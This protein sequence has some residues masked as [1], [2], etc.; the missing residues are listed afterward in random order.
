MVKVAPIPYL[1]RGTNI[2][3]NEGFLSPVE[4]VY[5]ERWL[6]L[7][8]GRCSLQRLFSSYPD[9]KLGTGLL[10]LRVLIGLITVF[11]AIRWIAGA[12]ERAAY[13]WV[14]GI[15]STACGVML[16]LGFKTLLAGVTASVSMLA[17][18][19]SAGSVVSPVSSGA[20]VLYLL[21]AILT[22]GLALTG[23]G[24][25]SIEGHLYGRREIVVPPRDSDT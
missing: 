13:V 6:F 11:L 15:I 21:T 7:E 10:L 4:S 2:F 9:G 14:M 5:F 25:F 8:P 18:A 20:F 19:F 17:I 22:L 16:I 23:P 12:P 3:R 1:Y 24:A